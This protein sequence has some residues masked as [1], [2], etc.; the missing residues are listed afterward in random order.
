MKSNLLALMSALIGASAS[1][2][3]T[4]KLLRRHRYGCGRTATL[5]E[6]YKDNKISCDRVGGLDL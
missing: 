1:G 4:Y 6:L 5:I 2:L 3:V